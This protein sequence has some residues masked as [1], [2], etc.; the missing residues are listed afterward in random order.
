MSFVTKLDNQLL[1]I[2]RP[3]KNEQLTGETFLN[4]N[5]NQDTIYFFFKFSYKDD[6]NKKHSY[7]EL[8]QKSPYERKVSIPNR[9]FATRIIDFLKANKL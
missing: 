4:R 5:T 1:N 6:N 7:N 3:A 8:Y 9:H 2:G